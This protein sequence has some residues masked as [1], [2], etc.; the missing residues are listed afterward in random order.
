VKRFAIILVLFAAIGAVAGI[1]VYR[2]FTQPAPK[3]ADLLPETT[4][5]LL[6]VP[7]FKKTREEFRSTELYALLHEPEIAALLERPRRVFDA[8]FGGSS[9]D[10]SRKLMLD[11]LQG[12][13]FLAVTSVSVF[14][15]LDA[16]VVFG[17]DVKQDRLQ[18]L[19]AV[20]ALKK[21]I[22]ELQPTASFKDKSHRGTKYEVWQIKPGV[23]VCHASF[24]SLVLF[25]LGETAMRAVI[26][27]FVREKSAGAPLAGSPGLTAVLQHVPA[28][29][30]FLAYVN[31]P[32][33][34]TLLSPLLLL[35]PQSAGMMK[36][37]ARLQSF[38]YGVT[39]QDRGVHEVAISAL[40]A[41]ESEPH[42]VVERK[43]LAFTSPQTLLYVA[44][45]GNLAA[46]Y[47]E[48]MQSL[49]QAGR[50]TWTAAATKFERT[51]RKRGVR[52][53]ED[54]LVKLG[55][56]SA[57]I[58]QWRDGA[59]FPDAALVTELTDAAN[60]RPALDTTMDVLRETGI[61]GM[62]DAPAWEETSHGTHTMRTVRIGA[63]LVAPAYVTTDKF[64][65][66]ALT[67]E[68]AGDLLAQE[69]GTEP[70]LTGNAEYQKATAS[71]PAKGTTYAYLDARG[72][73]TP[74]Y[75]L[76]T[77]ILSNAEG[78]AYFDPQTLPKPETFTKH[79]FPFT[80][81]TVVDGQAMIKT[82]FSP[83]SI[84]MIAVTAGALAAGA[85]APYL[86]SLTD[87]LAPTPSSDTDAL[88]P[89][90]ENQ[91][92]ESGTPAPQ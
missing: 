91:T 1:F 15:N 60:V 90:P 45:A 72:F 29:H 3:A 74:V 50:P 46:G 82:S 80:S 78:S 28:G 34:T 31:V 77:G 35:S 75:Q 62:E 8:A 65:I 58:A 56:E 63:G 20:I 53:R 43:T 89:A 84:P 32:E 6:E 41:A 66:F 51:V 76:V 2:H 42:S 73:F 71:F 5:L 85:S 23:T 14:P 48:A 17:V 87:Q 81:T 19:A 30:E 25:T 27:Q 24:H 92:E 33:I 55:P 69:A 10:K 68:F 16:S 21:R 37:L 22:R 49:S 67:P 57:L 44:A 70:T 11:A 61:E 64:L 7:D 26:G 18:A 52:L 39:F 54:L 38:G 47:D 13:V 9:D 40:K 4:L 88:P 12:E 83:V 36:K 59:R 79:L 86:N